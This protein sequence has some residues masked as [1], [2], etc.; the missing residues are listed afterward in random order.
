[1]NSNENNIMDKELSFK[2]PNCQS[3]NFDKT[4]DSLQCLNCNFKYIISDNVIRFSFAT[5]KDNTKSEVFKFWNTAPNE[6]LSVDDKIYSDSFFKNTEKQRYDQHKNF[7]IPFFKDVVG[8]ENY[9]NENILEVGCGIGIDSIQFARSGNNLTLLDLTY[10]SLLLTK[11]RL[12]NE[13]Y[14]ANYIEADSENLPFLKHSFDLV[15]SYGVIHHSPD[16]QK[17]IDEIYRVLKPK[18]EAIVML[19]N[20]HSA[21][22]YFNIFLNEGLRKRYLFKYKSFKELLNRRTELQSEKDDNLPV[23]TQAFS[24]KEVRHMFQKFQSVEIE[25]HYITKGM[26]AQMRHLL[27]FIPTSIKSR[28]H[29]YFGWNHIIKVKK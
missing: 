13:G 10:N 4:T 12:E 15:Y 22:V 17:S 19:Y 25:T 8:F 3:E 20:Y 29:K 2:C 1:M 11:S 27:P 14:N 18:G 16:T 5:I 26:F 23:L 9:K 6:S 28:L 7:E 21:M 24:K